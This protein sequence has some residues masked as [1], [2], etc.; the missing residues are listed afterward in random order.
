LQT[1]PYFTTRAGMRALTVQ[2]NQRSDGSFGVGI[3]NDVTDAF[4]ASRA[5]YHPRCDGLALDLG[6]N[7]LFATDQGDLIG[8]QWRSKLEYYDRRLTNLAKYLQKRSL[9]PSRHGRYRE[10]V[11][12][13][14]G[15]LE[16]EVGRCLNRLVAVRAPAELCL[17][18]S[19]SVRR[20]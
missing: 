3:L 19:T 17:S 8:R 1:Y 16:S 18:G 14:R 4:A 2:V 10:D 15:W 13:M 5:A 9:K 11:T 6:F 12:A 20:A 7:T